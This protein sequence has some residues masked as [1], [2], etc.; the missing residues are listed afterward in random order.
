MNRKI[1]GIISIVIVIFIGILMI[2]SE[3]DVVIEDVNTNNEID[4]QQKNIQT[5]NNEPLDEQAK[6]LEDMKKQV[7]KVGLSKLYIVKCSSCHGK[8]GKGP[9]GPSIA[10]KSYDYNMEAL[11]K[12]KN[13]QVE[14]TMMKGL[15]EKTPIE[16]L[17]ILAKEVSSFK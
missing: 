17:E 2:N 14:N 10:G 15:L 5:E 7:G 16:E 13:G 12:Y 8:D 11:L 9:V 3:S 4:T 1:V 6:A